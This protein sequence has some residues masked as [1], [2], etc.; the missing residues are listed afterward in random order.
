MVVSSAIYR[1][2]CEKCSSYN[3]KDTDEIMAKRERINDEI[4]GELHIEGIEILNEIEK[5][6]R[7]VESMSEVIHVLL[8]IS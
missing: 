2:M 6:R 3:S 4:G 1:E 7:K 8:F 5:E